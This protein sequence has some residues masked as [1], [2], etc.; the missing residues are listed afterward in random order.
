MVFPWQHILY[1]KCWWT[2]WS[3]RSEDFYLE[4]HSLA[5][6]AYDDD[7]RGQISQNLGHNWNMKDRN[8]RCIHTFTRR[9]TYRERRSRVKHV[10]VVSDMKNIKMNSSG[11]TQQFKATN[12]WILT[13]FSQK[14]LSLWCKTSQRNVSAP[15]STT[16]TFTVLLYIF[17]PHQI[18]ICHYISCNCIFMM[19]NGGTAL[20]VKQ[21][22]SRSTVLFFGTEV[23][24]PKSCMF[25]IC[26]Y[27]KLP[28]IQVSDVKR[29]VCVCVCASIC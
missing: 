21:T 10:L 25:D 5:A 13:F 23:N 22:A 29:S 9:A 18:L 1:E 4:N 14:N 3:E 2:Q 28:L 27:T 24:A 15:G 6:R 16:E 7:L 19:D 12:K 17:R 8:C 11:K 20:F 26:N